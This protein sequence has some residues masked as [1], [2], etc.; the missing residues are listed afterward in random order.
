MQVRRVGEH[1]P[2]GHAQRGDRGVNEAQPGIAVRVDDAVV[3]GRDRQQAG[4]IR[5]RQRPDE[6]DARRLHDGMVVAA[7]LAGV[8]DHGQR[9]DTGEQVPVAGHQ[10]VDDGGNWV[11]SGRSPG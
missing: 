1:R 7:V 4:V 3:A 9:L 8:V 6:P 11:T 10:F 5:G 2:A